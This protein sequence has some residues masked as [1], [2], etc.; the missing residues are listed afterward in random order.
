MVKRSSTRLTREGIGLSS[1]SRLPNQNQ[2]VFKVTF[3]LVISS[4]LIIQQGLYIPFQELHPMG[5]PS[6]GSVVGVA[7]NPI[8]W[9]H[10]L[11]ALSFFLV[12]VKPILFGEGDSGNV[13]FGTKWWWLGTWCIQCILNLYIYIY[14]IARG[15][16]CVCA[17]LHCLSLITIWFCNFYMIIWP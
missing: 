9:H 15:Y 17:Q 5:A 6:Q 2:F 13:R 7:E 8:W 16:L 12:A 3:L 4:H 10:L 14:T 11:E 1:H